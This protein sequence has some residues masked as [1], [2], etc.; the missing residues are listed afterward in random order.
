MIKFPRM[1][2]PMLYQIKT[3]KKHD[4]GIPI[5]CFADE[6]FDLTVWYDE[7]GS[8]ISF[9]LSYDKFKNPHAFTW[10]QEYGHIHNRIDDG[11]IP[12]RFKQSPILL[13]DGVFPKDGVAKRF[14]EE[15]K[16]IESG[17]V[18]FVLARI[19]EA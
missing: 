1:D 16:N 7:N 4:N 8:I 13:P 12:G 3:A 9:Q 18:D 11:E 2:I 14:E 10:K 5:K 17:I 6:Y 15:S 19:L